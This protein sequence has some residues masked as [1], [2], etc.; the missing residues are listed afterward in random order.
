MVIAALLIWAVERSVGI[1]P[2]GVVLSGTAA[3]ASLALLAA[4][5]LQCYQF[6]K[7]P[8]TTIQGTYA[9]TY[10]FFMGSTLGHLIL[11]GFIG[12]GMWNRARLG[13]YDNG[14]WHRVRVIRLFAVWIAISAVILTA[15]SSL[16]A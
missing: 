2:S 7:V 3:F 11:L 9:S 10:L 15:V 13:K 1:Q 5:A 6:G 4:V 14:H 16:F 12:I 8:F